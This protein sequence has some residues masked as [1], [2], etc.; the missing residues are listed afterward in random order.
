MRRN[1]LMT[2][3]RGGLF[4]ALLHYFNAEDRG[5]CRNVR[6]GILTAVEDAKERYLVFL[7]GEG[8]HRRVEADDSNAAAERK[9][10]G[11]RL[12]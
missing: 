2:S 9:Q 1:A 12:D 5:A 8:E 3:R 10:Q 4:R 6:L 11:V 7:N